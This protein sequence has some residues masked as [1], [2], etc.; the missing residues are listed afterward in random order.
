MWSK[1]NIFFTKNQL[2]YQDKINKKLTL[3]NYDLVV[4]DEI[5]FFK[6]SDAEDFNYPFSLRKTKLHSQKFS[7]NTNDIDTETG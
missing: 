5:E 6:T 4:Y 1:K 3:Y 7:I 2:A